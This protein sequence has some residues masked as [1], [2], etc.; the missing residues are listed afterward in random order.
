MSMYDYE[1]R[2]NYESES[3][4]FNAHDVRRELAERYKCPVWVTREG[5]F[6]PLAIMSQRHM[7][8]AYR[9]ICL[10]RSSAIQ[11]YNMIDHPF[12]GP[13]PDSMAYECASQEADHFYEEVCPVLD[14]WIAA[15]EEWFT[16]RGWPIPKRP[17]PDKM[18]EIESMETVTLPSG[19]TARIAK[20]KPSK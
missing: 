17:K 2:I 4:F 1:E 20:L 8:N 19:S 3:S 12:W 15:F 10:Q 9:V 7:T 11:A 18:P 14:A 13:D 6:V 5:D 16:K